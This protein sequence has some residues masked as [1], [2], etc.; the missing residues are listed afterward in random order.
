MTETNWM[1]EEA[2]FY[3]RSRELAIQS[4]II[5]AKEIITSHREILKGLVKMKELS[6]KYNLNIQFLN[7]EIIVEGVK[8]RNE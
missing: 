6:R 5:I 8:I 3:N 2:K 4:C 7:D 1:L